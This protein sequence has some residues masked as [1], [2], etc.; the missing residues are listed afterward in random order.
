[1]ETAAPDMTVVR[2]PDLRGR[3]PWPNS[4][5]L[6]RRGA[7]IG[8]RGRKA[9]PSYLNRVMPAEETEMHAIFPARG[10]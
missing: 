5:L 3:A 6:S 8:L 2:P 4:P 7:L 9:N 1:M 10:R